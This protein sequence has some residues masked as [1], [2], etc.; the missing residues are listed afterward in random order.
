MAASR[1][2]RW[3]FLRVVGAF[4]LGRGTVLAVGAQARDDLDG[5]VLSSFLVAGKLDFA[6]AAGAD[7]LA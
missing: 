2:V 4:T 5:D 1:A 7:G 6:H 3:D